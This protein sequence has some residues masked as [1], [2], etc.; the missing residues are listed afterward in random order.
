MI[1]DNV[2]SK[3]ASLQADEAQFA[4]F[5]VGGEE[6][7]IDIMRI[8]EIIRPQKVTRI[9]KAPEFVEGIINLRGK[10]VPV[11]DLRKRFG[12]DPEDADRKKIRI[13]IVK[14]AGRVLGVVVDEVTEVI[15]LKSDQVES[16][17]EAVKGAGADYLKGVGKVGD[18]LIVLL[19]MDKV[20]SGD[21]MMKLHAAEDM[22]KAGGMK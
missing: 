6:Y 21:E 22:A 14:M 8:M 9:P 13:V 12:I 18:R 20:L 1:K 2:R 15:Y 5:R 19:D 3:E 10:V 11:L 4:V 16:T 17:P 7:A